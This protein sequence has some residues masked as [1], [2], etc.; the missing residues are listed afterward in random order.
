M[1]HFRTRDIAAIA[2]CAS[3][4]GVLNSIFSP[5]IFRMFGL[6][7]LCDLIGFTLLT[8]TV[9]WI[10]KLGS[11]TAVGLI[12]TVITFMLNPTGT[13]FLGF[14]AAC[15]VFDVAVRLVGYDN[16]FSKTIQSVV[17]LVPISTMS[18]AVAGYLIGTF[19]MVAPALAR[20]GGVLG[21]AALHAVGGVIGGSIGVVLVNALRARRVVVPSLQARTI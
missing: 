10:R 7:I 6:P 11:A 17:T 9:W 18:A 15:I 16:A 1:P 4:W 21:W 3:L 13:Q 19:F 8:L 5:I 12:A 2:L 14:T 20:W